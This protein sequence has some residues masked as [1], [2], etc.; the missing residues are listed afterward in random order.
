MGLLFDKALEIAVEISEVKL[1]GRLGNNALILFK[2]ALPWVPGATGNC[3][4]ELGVEAADSGFDN[5]V[6]SGVDGLEDE[7]T[8][9]SFSF[10]CRDG[11]RA[12]SGA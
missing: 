11:C 1:P 3:G 12:R 8:W 6:G 10:D 7:L 9:C 5:E 4:V 2:I